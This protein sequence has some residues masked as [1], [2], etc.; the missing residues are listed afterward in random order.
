MSLRQRKNNKTKTTKLMKTTNKSNRKLT[1]K[2]LAVNIVMAL[3]ALGSIAF[4]ILE[5]HKMLFTAITSLT[6][7][8]SIFQTVKF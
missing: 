1:V 3:P 8:I 2:E 7:I 4:T 6:G 5:K